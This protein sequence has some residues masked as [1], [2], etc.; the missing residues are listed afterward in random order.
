MLLM[1]LD[2]FRTHSLWDCMDLCASSNISLMRLTLLASMVIEI[3]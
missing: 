1:I 3:D 2:N